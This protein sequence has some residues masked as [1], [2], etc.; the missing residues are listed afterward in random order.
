MK[1]NKNKLTA[2]D[3]INFFISK[4]TFDKSETD[5]SLLYGWSST[6]GGLYSIT[7]IYK[8]FEAKGH[9]SKDVDDVKFK[10][11]QIQSAFSDTEKLEKGKTHILYTFKIKNY[12]PDYIAN[13]SFVYYL[14]D[15]SKEEAF[16]LKAE[17]EA[18][19]LRLMQSFISK[20][21]VV[22]SVSASKA[23]RTKKAKTPKIPRVKKLALAEDLID[24]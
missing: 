17:Y 13:S 7:D 2:Q 3:I 9:D 5:A 18:E 19:S 22:K 23:N 20:M 24:F 11:I 8:Y 21:K 4:P 10:S 6:R 1:A 15:I 14:Y 16:K 12:S